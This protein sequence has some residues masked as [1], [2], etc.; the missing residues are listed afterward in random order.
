MRDAKAPLVDLGGKIELN[1]PDLMG[2]SK[3]LDKKLKPL[4]PEGILTSDFYFKGNPKVWRNAQINLSVKS[5]RVALSKFHIEAVDFKFNQSYQM[6]NQC[7]LSGLLYSGQLN[8]DL[9]ADLTHETQPFQATIHLAQ[10][11]LAELRKDLAFKD[12]DL[13]GVLDSSFTLNGSLTDADSITGQGFVS[14]KDGFLLQLKLLEGI[15]ETLAIKEFKNTIFTTAYGDFSVEKQ[16]I[17]TQNL[18]LKSES[19]D[20]TIRGWI[21]FDQKLSLEV[22]PQFSETTLAQSNS[23]FKTPSGV[24]SLASNYTGVKISGSLSSPKYVPFANP[25][26]FLKDTGGVIGETLKDILQWNF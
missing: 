10:A 23:I 9:T 14:V 17:A 13:K 7:K 22:N 4:K 25:V 8:G 24:I 3:D 12:Q 1:L 18:T 26:R 16:K 20:L 15:W 11:D 2:I 6:I 5:Q 21:G 19:V